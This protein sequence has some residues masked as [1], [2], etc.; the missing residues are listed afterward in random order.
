MPTAEETLRDFV[1]RFRRDAAG[2]VNLL[3]QLHLTG[4]GGG[5][6]QLQVADQ[7]CE[8]AA[9][10]AREPDVTITMAV[11]DWGELLAGRLDPYGAFLQGRVMV[12]GNLEAAMKLQS[13][14]AL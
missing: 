12:S 13:L 4:E 6:W 14:F 3:Y 9:G 8:L 1:T 10:V 11:E 7:K 2:G 5:S